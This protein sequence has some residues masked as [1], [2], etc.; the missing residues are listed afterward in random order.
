MDRFD[1]YIFELF[2]RQTH[3]ADLRAAAGARMAR[4]ALALAGTDAAPRWHSLHDL[5]RGVHQVLG[6]Y[7]PT[8]LRRGVARHV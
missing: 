5:A 7:I 6:R 3:N 8:G 2:A 4:E 1:P